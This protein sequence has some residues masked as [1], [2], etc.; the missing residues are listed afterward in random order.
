[1]TT[2]DARTMWQRTASNRVH[3]DTIRAPK[4]AHCPSL[5]K[6]QPEMCHSEMVRG[7]DPA[8]GSYYWTNSWSSLDTKTMWQM[9][10]SAFCDQRSE[11]LAL[12]EFLGSRCLKPSGLQELAAERTS[13]VKLNSGMMGITSDYATGAELELEWQLIVDPKP[14]SGLSASFRA[15][16]C[17][18]RNDARMRNA[19]VGRNNNIPVEAITSMNKNLHESELTKCFGESVEVDE[20][21]ELERQTREQ[22]LLKESM[23]KCQ[24]ARGNCTLHGS[25]SIC[26]TGDASPSAMTTSISWRTANKEALATLVAQKAKERLENCD[27]PTPLS[28]SV[29][30]EPLESC[31]FIADARP[32]SME[33]FDINV[34]KSVLQAGE[35]NRGESLEILASP[36][37]LETEEASYST[38]QFARMSLPLTIPTKC[39]ASSAMRRG[40]HSSSFADN[41]QA[42]WMG[43]DKVMCASSLGRTSGPLGEALCHSQTRAREA[44]KRAEE[45]LQ[46]YQRVAHLFFREASLSFTYRQWVGSLQAE[47]AR[48]K[49]YVHRHHQQTSVRL[50]QSVLSPFSSLDRF[51]NSGWKFGRDQ[52]RSQLRAWQWHCYARDHLNASLWPAEK[53]SPVSVVINGEGGA[54]I[55]MGCTLSFA[56]ALGL[57]LAGAGFMLGWSMG[58]ILLAY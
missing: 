8:P 52:T 2:S 53:D 35:A 32:E 56:F 17:K 20:R 4:L 18:M 49:M 47:N 42:S 27:L 57:S 31:D 15:V 38:G 43:G 5:P 55:I 29:L 25:Q 28:R 7:V 22:V 36:N 30:K 16:E 46:N 9:S 6:P 50:Q 54:E 13:N 58:W 44:D 11:Y 45:S 33:S 19:A 3:D 34:M 26:F 10:P 14:K 23:G 12:D 1:M 41:R 51:T 48:L 40:C 21:G 39:Q 24:Q 37:V